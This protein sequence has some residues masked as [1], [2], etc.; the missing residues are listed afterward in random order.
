MT[1]L[2]YDTKNVHSETRGKTTLEFPHILA[3][4]VQA[5]AYLR[6]EGKYYSL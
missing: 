4:H 1:V 2:Q 6:T 3:I 5:G